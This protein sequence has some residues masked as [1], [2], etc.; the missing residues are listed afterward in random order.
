M[1]RSRHPATALALAAAL[2]AA[3]A[4]AGA[5][6]ETAAKE[7]VPTVEEIV[8]KA[9]QVSYY[10][11]GTGRARVKMTIKDAEGRVRGERELVILRRNV[12]GGLDQK[13]YV[14]FF[15][16]VDVRGTVFLVW[17][18]S[19][20]NDDRWLYNPGL[21]LVNRIAG[22][23]K[24]TS[25]VGSHFFY[26]DVS[27]RSIADDTHELVKTTTDYYVLKNTPKDA[28]QVEFSYYEMYIHRDTFLPLYAYY[29]DK[30]GEKYREYRVL[31]MEEIGGYWTAVRAEMRDLREQ[32]KE[33]AHTLAEYSDIK[34]GMELPDEIFTQRYLRKAPREYLR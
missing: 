7:E 12:E 2:L 4:F 26:E 33:T 27:G 14:Y 30:N 8:K 23:D 6:G 22:T 16:P 20:K 19:D 29:Y 1:H 24:R 34:Y 21:D 11:A 9:N 10:Q 25:F 31:K 13:Y 5:Q 17:K 32:G 3:A 18:H 15:R 28:D